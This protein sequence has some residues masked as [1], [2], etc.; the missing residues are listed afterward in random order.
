MVP[1]AYHTVPLA[2]QYCLQA[3]SALTSNRWA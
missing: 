3:T 2:S 1:S